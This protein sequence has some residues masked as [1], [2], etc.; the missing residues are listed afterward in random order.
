M[1]TKPN[2][3]GSS[4]PVKIG[5]LK[6]RTGRGGNYG[7]L[8]VKQYSEAGKEAGKL[9]MAAIVA[10]ADQNAEWNFVAWNNSLQICQ[11]TS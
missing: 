8:L 9:E 5:N 7:P 6:K 2:E 11:W 1:D 3:S 10:D 4:V